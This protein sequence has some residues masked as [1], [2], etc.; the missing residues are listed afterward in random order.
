MTSR[1][2]FNLFTIS[3]ARNVIFGIATLWIGLFHSDYMTLSRIT[4]NQFFIDLFGSFRGMGNIGVDMFL[5]LS[6]VGLFFSFSKDSEL[7][8]RSV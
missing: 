1:K 5:F 4:D 6:G 3:E 2:T 8:R 7:A